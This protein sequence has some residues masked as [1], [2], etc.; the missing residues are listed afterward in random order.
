MKNRL[1]IKLLEFIWILLSVISISSIVLFTLGRFSSPLVLIISTIIVAIFVIIFKPK[2]VFKDDRFNIW[3]GLILVFALLI[4]IGPWQDL[5]GGQ[6]QGIY[7]IMSGLIE[8]EGDTIVEDNLLNKLDEEDRATYSKEKGWLSSTALRQIDNDSYQY[9][10]YPLFPSL[11]AISSYISGDSLRLY[12]LTIFAVFSILSVYL[13]TIEI[14]K[15]NKAG[16]LAAILLAIA[17][18]HMYFSRFTVTEVLMITFNIFI[19]Y[20]LLK[21]IREKNNMYL[22]LSVMIFILLLFTKITGIVMVVFLSIVFFILLIYSKK[23]DYLKYIILYSGYIYLFVIS[24]VFYKYKIFYLYTKFYIRDVFSIIPENYF[25]LFFLILPILVFIITKYLNKYFKV[26]LELVYRYRVVILYA[27][28][29]FLIVAGLYFFYQMAFT[30]KYD[31]SLFDY[32]WGMAGSGWIVLKDTVLMSVLLHLTPVGLIFIAIFFYKQK[33]IP[34]LLLSIFFLIFLSFN[35]FINKFTP[36]QYYYARYLLSEVFP[37]AMIMIAI[38]VYNLR[39]Y[40]L[41]KLNIKW[42]LIAI[43]IMYG[44]LFS[45]LQFQ[46]AHGADDDFFK[47]VQTSI[48]NKKEDLIIYYEPTKFSYSYVFAPLRDYYGYNSIR[49][50]TKE[51]LNQYIDSIPQYYNSNIYIITPEKFDSDNRVEYIKTLKYEKGFYAAV[52]SPQPEMTHT[53]TDVEIPYCDR[54][55]PERYCSGILPVRYHKAYRD[56]YL[57]IIK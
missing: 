43:Y 52:E 12:T 16:Y 55:L 25:Y 10:F 34:S 48:E 20:Y 50:G 26:V 17:P 51:N 13:L 3:I 44:M 41:F 8:R 28:S 30:D 22:M 1:E 18:L 47:E 27:I 15:N 19:L 53:V 49:T 7:L 33:D 2:I 35:I 31:N 46:G 56:M 14:S 39:D 36:Y 38:A 42:I 29:T 24:L 4:R 57:Y 40:F 37:V 9:I 32:F 6:D 45:L 21:G 54:Y 11:M 23:E 5:E